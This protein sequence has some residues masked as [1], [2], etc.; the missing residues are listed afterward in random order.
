MEKNAKVVIIGGGVVGCSILYH[1]SKFGLKDCILLERNELTSGSSWHAA[2]NVH[3]ISS[4]PNISRMMAYTIGLYKEIEKESGHSV[5]FKP[6]GG[7]YLASNDVWAEYLKRE[8]S[9]ARYMGL[10]QEFISLDE[11]KKK[12][13]LID[14][15]N[16]Y[17]LYGIQSMV[18]LIH[19]VLLMLLQKQL[20][21]MEVNITLTRL[22]K[23]QNKGQMVLG[24]YLQIK[25]VLMLK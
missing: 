4:D 24:T 3:V 7:F 1:L 17:L 2:G 11:V 19:Q 25:E 16:T 14:P 12:H 15:K 22:L 18:K 5:G 8:R 21:F 23:I 13:P 10:D 6:S 9:K 20:K